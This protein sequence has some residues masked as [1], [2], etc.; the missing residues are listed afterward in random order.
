MYKISL[1]ILLPVLSVLFFLLI[2]LTVYFT[3]KQVLQHDTETKV[4]RDF[5]NS[6]NLM[7]GAMQRFLLLEHNDGVQ[8]LVSSVSSDL[9]LQAIFV[10]DKSGKVIASSSFEQLNSAWETL[11]YVFDGDLIERVV[12]AQGSEIN[13]TDGGRSVE[14]VASIC[15]PGNSRFLRPERCGFLYYKISL[16]Y[17]QQEAEKILWQ[18]ARVS[19]AGLLVTAILFGVFI[20]FLVVRRLSKVR[21]TLKEYRQGNRLSRTNLKGSDEVAQIAHYVD[22]LM[23]YLRFEEELLRQSEEYKQI[24]ID[25]AEYCIISTSVDGTIESFNAVAQRLLGYSEEELV[26]KATPALFHDADEIVARA[27]VLSKQLSRKIE[28][29]FEVFVT[30]TRLGLRDENDWTYIAKDQTRIPVRLS[31]TALKG[32]SGQITGFLGVAQDIT[33]KREIEQSLKLSK[34][35]FEHAGEAILITDADRRIIDANPKYTGLM[36]YTLEEVQGQRPSIHGSGM[37]EES[38]FQALW[39]DVKKHG[40]WHGEIWNRR[41]NGELITTRHQVSTIKNEQGEIVNYIIIFNDISAQ[42]KAEE[43]LEQMA[44]FDALTGLPNRTLFKDRFQ[45]QEQVSR[46]NNSRFA[47]MYLDLDRFKNVNDTLGHEIGDQLLVEVARRISDCVRES[48]TVSRLGGDEFTVILPD[49]YDTTAIGAVAQNIIDQL[50]QV[51]ILNKHEVYIGASVGITIY[52]DDGLNFNSLNKNADAAMYKAKQEGRGNYCFFSKQMNAD[53]ERLRQLEN[54]LRHA[55][56]YNELVLHYQ[57]VMNIASRSVESFEVFLRWQHP[58]K[59]LLL[60]EDFLAVAEDIGL[61]HE[62][63]AWVLDEVDKCLQRWQSSES[64][65]YSISVNLSIKQ[66]YHAELLTMIKRR[67]HKEHLK[68]RKIT[69]DITEAVLREQPDAAIQRMRELDEMGINLAI[70]GFGAGYMSLSFL[71]KLP[72]RSIKFDRSLIQRLHSD[73]DDAAFLS[74]IISLARRFHLKVVAVGVETGTQLVYLQSHACDAVQ[75]YYFAEPIAVE[76]VEYLLKKDGLHFDNL[77]EERR[78]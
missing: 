77:G 62:I 14:A 2:A 16:D 6:V 57:P 8:Q 61:T 15:N 33:E 47:L 1:Q 39:D 74:S 66:F 51:F 34:Q 72:I 50:Q 76:K 20:H 25:S 31:V 28:P 70:D 78:G 46:R 3:T 64:E 5:Q 45:H 65:A 55:L 7:Q 27:K 4:L 23:A 35:V 73:A 26:G 41:K 13:K 42:K 10:A 12:T 30:R 75:G 49:V 43:Q 9:S 69:F 60:P 29:G 52:P 54:D 17:Y 38:F 68:R 24:I 22:I 19:F 67:V 36:G 11:P 59:G 44:Y 48:D 40:S 37:H 18:Q 63:G 21:D 53:N 71:R 58:Q 32:E 56:E